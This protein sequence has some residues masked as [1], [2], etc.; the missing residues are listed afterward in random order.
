MFAGA[1]ASF[2]AVV[3]GHLDKFW[4]NCFMGS[5]TSS[6][7]I[8]IMGAA[9]SYG[10]TILCAPKVGFGTNPLAILASYGIKKL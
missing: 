9:T 7:T 4:L 3:C 2:G 8:A 1:E 10:T 5:K 6:G